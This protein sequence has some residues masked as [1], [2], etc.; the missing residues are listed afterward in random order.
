MPSSADEHLL[1][2]QFDPFLD[3]GEASCLALATYR[4]M[5]FA[6]DDLAARRLS[7]ERNASITGTLGVLIEMVQNEILSL[8][9]AN[10]ILLVMIKEDYRSP[11]KRLDE[12][13]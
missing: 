12:F 6:T 10:E 7:L 3:P 11:V 2:S 9:E 1:R 13:L 5:I 8:K 4:E